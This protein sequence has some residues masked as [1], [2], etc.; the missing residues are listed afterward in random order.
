MYFSRLNKII[1]LQRDR[2]VS[3][4]R[5][6]MIRVNHPHDLIRQPKIRVFIIVY[7]IIS[8]HIVPSRIYLIPRAV[9]LHRRPDMTVPRYSP[10][11]DPYLIQQQLI[12]PVIRFTGSYS[13]GKNAFRRTIIVIIII[14]RIVY[15]PVMEPDRLIEIRRTCLQTFFS[16][17]AHPLFYRRIFLISN[18]KFN[19]L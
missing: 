14:L 12:C 8:A 1:I 11:W 5:G 15:N 16:N 9:H 4:Y 6:F 10:C 3:W 17:A 18:G 19:L 2:F 13:S 7:R